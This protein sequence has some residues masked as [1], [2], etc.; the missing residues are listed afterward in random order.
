MN[1][2]TKQIS[3]RI[4]EEHAEELERRA[5]LTGK[6]IHEYSREILI[7][8]LT[9]SPA[10]ETRNRVAEVQDEVR[11]L[12]EDLHTSVVGILMSAGKTTLEEA[13]E[14]VTTKLS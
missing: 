10:E 7:S 11:R 5:K 1:G 6:S 3:F 4:A 13:T 9:R 2:Y 12:R 14:F 8:V